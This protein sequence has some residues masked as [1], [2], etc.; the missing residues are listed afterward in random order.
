MNI[1]APDDQVGKFN[2]KD[3]NGLRKATW[4]GTGVDGTA[5]TVIPNNCKRIAG[6][7]LCFVGDGASVSDGG[8]FYLNN[9]GDG[10]SYHETMLLD[11][12][13][14][15]V[16][17]LRVDDT[18]GGTTPGKVSVLRVSGSGTTATVFLDFVWDE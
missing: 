14:S 11:L 17:K 16:Y 15:G 2:L 7:Y 3:A 5:Q 6:T 13:A 1:G 9:D 10:S 4:S 18:A 8:S 12:G